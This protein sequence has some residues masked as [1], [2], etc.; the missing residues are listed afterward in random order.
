MNYSLVMEQ[1]E[2][3]SITFGLVQEGYHFQ[4]SHF[5]ECRNSNRWNDCSIYFRS[6]Q[7]VMFVEI[8]LFE[9]PW[10]FLM[11]T[12]PTALRF[13]IVKFE[14]KTAEEDEVAVQNRLMH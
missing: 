8:I 7:K 9:E 13:N 10:G 6:N 4:K 1:F 2:R 5:L 12:I 3:K 14:M 11:N